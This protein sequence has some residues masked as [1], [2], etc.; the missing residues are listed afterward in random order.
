[1]FYT[2][3]R[4]YNVKLKITITAF[5]TFCLFAAANLAYDFPPI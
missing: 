2:D 4:K 3:Q 1:M 5:E